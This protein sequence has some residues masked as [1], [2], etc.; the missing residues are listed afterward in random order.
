MNRKDFIYKACIFCV[1]GASVSII[2]SCKV[3][4]KIVKAKINGGKIKVSNEDLKIE[5]NLV[6]EIDELPYPVFF[7]MNALK[8]VH[9]FYMKCT[10]RDYKLNFKNNEFYCNNHGSR[11][12][13]E[14]KIIEGPA[15][16][17]LL[18]LPVIILQ[19]GYS[20]DTSRIDI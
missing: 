17:N 1:A 6:L 11:Y 14:G 16:I 7:S 10:H 20:I 15:K 4:S 19:D 2:D 5:K 3:S 12:N 18:E 13:F 9:S 8:E